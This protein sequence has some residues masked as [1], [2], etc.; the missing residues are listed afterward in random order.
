MTGKFVR[1]SVRRWTAPGAVLTL[2]LA[3]GGVAAEEEAQPVAAPPPSVAESLEL[4]MTLLP[5]GA[6]GPASVI[7]TIE[8][9]P[10]ARAGDRGDAA[11]DTAAQARERREFGLDTAAEARELGREFGLD[12][13]EQ[14]REDAGRGGDRR[15]DDVPAPPVT[16]PVTPPVPGPAGPPAQ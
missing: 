6:T 3:S 11:S 10:Q 4:T 2:L 8:L 12:R 7:S 13:A 5:E 15:P 16:L 1:A 14:A 9:P